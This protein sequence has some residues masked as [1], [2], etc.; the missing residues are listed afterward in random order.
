[1]VA[2]VLSAFLGLLLAMSCAS[3]GRSAVEVE[4]RARIT[5]EGILAAQSIACDMGGYMADASGRT[6]TSTQYS[7]TGWDVSQGNILILSFQGTTGSD[8]IVITYQ[9]SGDK[10]MRFNSS[11]GVTTTIARYVTAFA[12][13]SNAEDASQA[14]IQFTVTFRYFKSTFTLIGI[15]PT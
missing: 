13:G 1:L 6:G 5:Q 7:F 14:E 4:S 10:L 9:L 11:T 3:F 15:S 2:S 12:V 8:V